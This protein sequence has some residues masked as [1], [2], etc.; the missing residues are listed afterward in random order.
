M[1]SAASLVLTPAEARTRPPYAIEK[2]A[3]DWGVDWGDAVLIAHA[4]R[5]GG[6]LNMPKE[7]KNVIRCAAE[8]IR[9]A[10]GDG[11][12]RQFYDALKRALPALPDGN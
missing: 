7:R 5:A 6:T 11:G 3:Q 1:A 10:L 12:S 2:V 9:M 4:I 8:R